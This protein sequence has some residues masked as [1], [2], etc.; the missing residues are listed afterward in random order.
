MT[1]LIMRLMSKFA[2]LECATLWWF[3]VSA[4]GREKEEKDAEKVK[5]EGAISAK[6]DWQPCGSLNDVIL[7]ARAKPSL[8]LPLPPFIINTS[9]LHP[10]YFLIGNV[11]MWMLPSF[12]DIRECLVRGVDIAVVSKSS[13]RS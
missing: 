9:K 11:L 3:N 5:I 8:N 4:M 13:G 7:V 10:H 2:C 6:A 1:L 12:F